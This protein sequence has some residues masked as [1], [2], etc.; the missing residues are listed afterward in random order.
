M[1]RLH[2]CEAIALALELRADFLILDDRDARIEASRRK[3]MV[4]GTLRGLEDVAQLGLI[5]LP[6]ALPRLR[7]TTFRA[8]APKPRIAAKAGGGI[9]P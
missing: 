8:C 6:H 7:Q 2:L 5:D 4:I 1:I 3:L 9:S